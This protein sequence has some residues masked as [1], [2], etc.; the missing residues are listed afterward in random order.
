MYCGCCEKDKHWMKAIVGGAV[1]SALLMVAGLPV[2]HPAYVP[3]P[4]PWLLGIFVLL[5][6]I[7]LPYYLIG[8]TCEEKR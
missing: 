2:F 3:F 8:H 7:T 6:T 5:L 1:L 4:F